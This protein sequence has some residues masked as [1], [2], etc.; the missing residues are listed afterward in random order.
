MVIDLLITDD[1]APKRM[2]ASKQSSYPPSRSAGGIARA[3]LY[4]GGQRRP[5]SDGHSPPWP[6]DAAIERRARELRKRTPDPQ[7]PVTQSAE[8]TAN[9]FQLQDPGWPPPKAEFWPFRIAP[10]P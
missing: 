3:G 9:L 6:G 7:P 5:A 1:I 8:E 2:R 10:R 4:R